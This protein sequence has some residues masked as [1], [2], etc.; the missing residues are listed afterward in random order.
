MRAEGE[1]GGAARGAGKRRALLG[2]ALAAGG[3]ALLGLAVRLLALEVLRV[4]SGAMAPSLLAG[5]LVV[6][7]KAA[8]GLTNP[9]GGRP[10]ASWGAPR[11]GDVVVF[12][13]PREAG[14]WIRRVVGLPGDVVE[15]RGGVLFV[16][17]VAQPQEPAGELVWEEPGLDG[18][19]WSEPCP[20]HLERLARG[21]VPPPR[22]ASARAEAEAWAAAE[23]GGVLAHGV[24]HCRR[25]GAPALE[26]PPGRVEPG[27]VLVV[28]DN[29]ERSDD[30]RSPGG[31][32][33]PIAAV[34][35]RAVRV[36]LRWRAAGGSRID[37]LFKRIE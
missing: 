19:W 33:V 17:G 23:R 1:G 28:G 12:L 35:G 7:W 26:T 37:R 14:S 27:H 15:V 22:D 32:Q 6:V 25:T 2:L 9:L 3:A 11:R 20:R 34:Q 4:P 21:P 36:A 31:W 8:F 29:R 16:N 18:R 13:H 5:D 24:L 10:L 30:A